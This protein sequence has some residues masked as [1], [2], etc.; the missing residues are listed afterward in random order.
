MAS[1]A[2]PS[3]HARFFKACILYAA[4]DRKDAH[5]LY[6][7][8]DRFFLDKASIDAGRDEKYAEAE[9]LGWIA[10]LAFGDH[11]G[12]GLTEHDRRVLASTEVLI[13]LCSQ[14][15]R[16]STALEDAVK[17]FHMGHN[18]PKVLAAIS[19]WGP[20]ANEGRVAS[21]LPT[22]LQFEIDRDGSLSDRPR[23]LLAIDLNERPRARPLTKIVSGVMDVPF[24]AVWK[25]EIKAQWARLWWQLP[26]MLVGVALV[27]VLALLASRP[28]VQDEIAAQNRRLLPASDAALAGGDI[29]RAARLALIA[30]Y[31]ERAP[32][33]GSNPDAAEQK[34]RA[35]LA[36]DVRNN[37][38]ASEAERAAAL[39]SIESLEGRALFDLACRTTLGDGRGRMT[40]GELEMIRSDPSTYD[41]D[42]C[43]YPQWAIAD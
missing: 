36:A 4:P 25:R 8:L 41:G 22:S 31:A 35:A 16:Q 18:D 38:A 43:R 39:A 40:G 33:F 19:A 23:E 20:S 12:T 42:L 13:V 27:L 21:T 17:S 2:G 32:F 11:G 10:S 5:W 26:L 29:Q 6:R 28:V 15:A 1:A 7:E 3:T 14:A 37:V 30:A 34:L 24:D 9:P